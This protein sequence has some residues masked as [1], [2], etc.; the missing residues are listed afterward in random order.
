MVAYDPARCLP[1][2]QAAVKDF[3]FGPPG[4]GRDP[5]DLHEN[6]SV[7]ADLHKEEYW[8]GNE[9]WAHW[10]RVG[11]DGEFA[12]CAWAAL[13]PINSEIFTAPIL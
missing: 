12:E 7:A 4:V 9:E 13:A 5:P 10:T 6:I 8:V 1:I 3:E 2:Y 11:R